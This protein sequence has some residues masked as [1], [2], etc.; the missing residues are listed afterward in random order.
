MFF[1]CQC[2]SICY[3]KLDFTNNNLNEN[4]ILEYQTKLSGQLNTDEIEYLENEKQFITQTIAIQPEMQEQYLKDELSRDEYNTHMDDYNSYRR[5]EREFQ[6]IYEKWQSVKEQ[7]EPWV[8]YDYYWQKLL[9]QKNVVLFQIIAIIFLACNV[10][11]IEIKNGFYPILNS[12]PF[13][14]WK[15][16]KCKVLYATISS[17]IFSLMFSLCNFYVY[18][19]A[20][21][22]PQK[23]A[24]LYNISLFSNVDSSLTLAQYFW[25]NAVVRMLLISLLCV[26]IVLV[27]Y[28]WKRSSALFMSLCT[29]TIVSEMAYMIFRFQYGLPVSEIF[30]ANWILGI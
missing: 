3:V 20:Y 28:Y 29:V 18:N 14:R 25:L 30:Q 1:I 17:S 11:L 16:L 8:V 19:K 9:D 5:R 2:I 21:V 10:M 4:I 24:P 23:G 27:C 22:L 26:T 12:T 13:G 15:V 7:E 6:Y